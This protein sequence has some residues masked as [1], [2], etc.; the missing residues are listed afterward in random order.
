MTDIKRLYGAIGGDI[1]GSVYE[2][3]NV[4]T[5]DFPLF[6]PESTFTDDTIMTIAT[7]DAIMHGGDFAAAY[8]KWGRKYMQPTGG[9][10]A[11]FRKW[12]ESDN[13]QPYNSWGNGAA[14]RVS[15][16]AWV[17]NDLKKIFI[18]ARRSAECTH[19]HP[20]GI[21]GAQATACAVF[22]AQ[23][24][25][26]TKS[27]IA[28]YLLNHMGIN[29]YT[30]LDDIRQTYQFSERAVDTVPVAIRAFWESTDYVDAIRNAV[31]IGGDSDTIAAITGSVS[32][33][34]YQSIPEYIVYEIEKRLPIEMKEIVEEFDT[35][36]N[37]MEE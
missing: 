6:T 30:P 37:N 22:L 10:G 33:A 15:P 36:C 18:N 34:Y 8:R 19:D 2:F 1:I 32:L 26:Y 7:A 25:G 35:Y 28:R 3:N 14:M 21:R 20:E 27:S 11:A 16:V 31:S 24:F 4:K 29:A 13:P 5:K 17:F 23:R 9:Y 12:L